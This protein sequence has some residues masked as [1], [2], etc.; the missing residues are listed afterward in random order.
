MDINDLLQAVQELLS[1][2]SPKAFIRVIQN[3]P[4]LLRKETID[5]L[6]QLAQM[7]KAAGHAEFAEVLTNIA[8]LLEQLR[9]GLLSSQPSEA[10][11]KST[12]SLSPKPSL[13]W[14]RLTRQYLALRKDELLKQAV[15]KG[16]R[17]EKNQSLTCYGRFRQR[18]LKL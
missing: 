7:A 8:E 17:Q 11:P 14:A 9:Q 1:A 15:E 13:Q 18:I 16:S 6:H 3:H 5:Q 4:D 2:D 10:E 12:I